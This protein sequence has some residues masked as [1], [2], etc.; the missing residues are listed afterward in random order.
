M[1]EAHEGCE[2]G[3]GC[4]EIAGGDPALREYWRQAPDQELVCFCGQVSKGQIV[5][6]IMLGAYT[7]P[8]IK[9]M[10]GA[11]QGR[12]CQTKNPRGRCCDAD[13]KCL[14]EL[15]ASRPSFSFA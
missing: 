12:D 5:R 3:C 13:V 4:E 11:C 2:C 10:T 1:G 9:I 6:A 14:I 8:V 15:H 7:I